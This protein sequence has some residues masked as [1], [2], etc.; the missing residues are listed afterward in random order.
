MGKGS[1]DCLVTLVER[2]T[3]FLLMGKLPDRTTRSLNDM[4]VK[5]TR[6]SPLPVDTITADNGTEFHQYREIEK[7]TNTTFYFVP[8]H[9]SWERGSNENT[10]GLIKQYVPKGT[11]KAELTQTHCKAIQRRLNSRTRKRYDFKTPWELKN[12]YQ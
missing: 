11:S 6:K 8:P 9:Q 4:T 5:L 10:N 7:K 12:E 2:A 3:G 1:K